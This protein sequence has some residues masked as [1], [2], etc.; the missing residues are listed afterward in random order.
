MMSLWYAAALLLLAT[1][2]SGC[3]ENLANVAGPTPDLTPTFSSIQR[4]IFQTTDSAGR[5][6]CANCHN[7]NGGA[8]R[9]VGLDLS[10]DAAYALLVGVPSREKPG[11]LRVAPG[12][13]EN[14]YIIHKLEGRAGIEGLRMPRSGP[15]YLTDGQISIIKRW[16]QLGARRD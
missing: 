1:L 10:S 6:A 15:P 12:D 4:D 7:P 3:D 11:L 5:A 8:F 13:P 16:I 9:Q 14:S 2:A